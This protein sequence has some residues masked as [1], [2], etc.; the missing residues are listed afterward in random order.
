VGPL[1]HEIVPA[2]MQWPIGDCGEAAS[3]DEMAIYLI[4]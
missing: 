4:C 2:G 1:N 3:N